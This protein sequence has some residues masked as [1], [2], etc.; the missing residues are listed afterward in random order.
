MP[1]DGLVPIPHEV[2]EDIEFFKLLMPQFNEISVLDKSLVPCTQ[3]LE[4]DSCLTGCGALCGDE[5][6]SCIFPQ[7]VLEAQRTIAHLE[8]LNAVVALHMWSSEWQGQKL[9]INCDNSN[10]VIALQRGRSH[11]LFMQACVHTVF[12]LTVAADI[13]L[14]VCH[15]PSVFLIAAEAH[16]RIPTSNRFRMVLHENGL[17]EGKHQVLVPERY[18]EIFD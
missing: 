9:M 11:D 17:L 16:S 7:K 13:E 14:V 8:L 5:F 1:K 3:Q 4:I 18:F 10:T 6:Y 15:R 2:R 12:L